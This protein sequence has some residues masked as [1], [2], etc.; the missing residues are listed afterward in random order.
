MSDISFEPVEEVKAYDCYCG[1]SI[2]KSILINK[3]H[4]PECHIRTG[5]I[6]NRED[7]QELGWNYDVENKAFFGKFD[8]GLQKP[9]GGKIAH[10]RVKP[11]YNLYL[12]LKEAEEMDRFNDFVEYLGRNLCVRKR[13]NT[14]LYFFHTQQ[15]AYQPQVL[16]NL[17]NEKFKDFLENK[18]D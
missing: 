13:G 6:V 14:D 10:D 18:L 2:D 7:M 11:E 15:P 4:C 9:I 1:N 12:I 16:V 17:F 3:G 5:D 8:I